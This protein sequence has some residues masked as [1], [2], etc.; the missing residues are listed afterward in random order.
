VR[1]RLV[2]ILSAG[3]ALIANSGCVS[4]CGNYFVSA[5]PSPDGRVKA[6]VFT[7]DRGAITRDD[8]GLSVLPAD[9]GAPQGS[10]NALT[11]TDDP[12]HPIERSSSAIEVRLKWISRD[13][14]SVS[15]PRAAAVRKRA[16]KVKGV[17]IEY[18]TF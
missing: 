18:S 1:F 13:R 5:Q 7:R 2:L 15:F 4:P 12:D 6:V 8:T 16:A 11:I 17:G 10:A 14:L 3:A 9:A